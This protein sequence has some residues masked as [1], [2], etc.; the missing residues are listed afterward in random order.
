MADFCKACSI[1]LF[2]KDFEDHKG[3]TTE[4]MWK[5]LHAVTVICEGCGPI[6]VDPEG[7]CVSKDCLCSKKKG[8]GMPWLGEK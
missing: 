2:G 3:I 1:E 8:H 4:Q 5:E 7:N 6:Q